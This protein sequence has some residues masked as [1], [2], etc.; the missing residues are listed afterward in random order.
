MQLKSKAQLDKRQDEHECSLVCSNSAPIDFIL[1]C[2]DDF[3]AYV[4]KIK[5][6]QE[7]KPQESSSSE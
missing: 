1:Y 5:E 4:L 2:L 3:K 7:K 6:E